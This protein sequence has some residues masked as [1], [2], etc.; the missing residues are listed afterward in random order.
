MVFFFSLNEMFS[1]GKILKL[2]SDMILF[3]KR[4]ILAAIVERGSREIR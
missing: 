2:T 4:I 1:L 3:V